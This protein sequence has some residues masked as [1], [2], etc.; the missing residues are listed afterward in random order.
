MEFEKEEWFCKHC[1]NNDYHLCECGNKICI[2]C[3]RVH[4]GPYP[5][6]YLLAPI[7]V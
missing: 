2:N 7:E 3:G 4:K 6:P 1:N 5:I